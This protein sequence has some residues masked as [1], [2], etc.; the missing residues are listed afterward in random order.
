[1]VLTAQA[2]GASSSEWSAGFTLT[3]ALSMLLMLALWAGAWALVT[4]IVHQQFHALGHL[5]VAAAVATAWT[6]VQG[7]RGWFGFA[8][9]A[10]GA[11]EALDWVIGFGFSALLLAGHLSLATRLAPRGVRA[12]TGGVLAALALVGFA[13]NSSLEDAGL[14]VLSLSA[15][16]PLPVGWIPS[17]T[18]EAF[19]EEILPLAVELDA[20][21]PD[22]PGADQ[23]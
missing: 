18:L 11:L 2:L 20:L 14:D 12:W 6:L 13:V 3:L 15:L 8:Y 19:Q 7:A 16:K 4:R 17:Q 1:L 23:P 10:T 9:P 21:V 22:E 5:G